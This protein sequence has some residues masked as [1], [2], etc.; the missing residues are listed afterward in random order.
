MLI[1]VFTCKELI[2]R[3]D[4]KVACPHFSFFYSSSTRGT[5]TYWGN[6]D[7]SPET[8]LGYELGMDYYFSNNDF[9]K[10]TLYYNNAE[11]FIYSVV[12]DAQNSD[13]MNIDE[14]V[15]QGVEIEA[16][17]MPLSNLELSASYTYNDSQITKNQFN[18]EL[19]GNQLISV[20]Q[21]QANFNVRYNPLA[22]TTLLASI[23]HVGK[24]Y[25]NDANTA[26]YSPYTIYNTGVIY[27]F[28]PMFSAKANVNNIADEIYEG[29]G[30]LAPGRIYSA[31]LQ[32]NF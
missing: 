13:K 21:Q 27:R 24:R 5:I 11:N 6:P 16:R 32:V 31:S 29:I 12:R 7:L 25:A 19:E 28:S 20:P 22:S 8:V 23:E 1:H 30:Y 15:T 26:D 18:P 17:Y 2:G 10:A 3:I 4:L 9:I 14:V